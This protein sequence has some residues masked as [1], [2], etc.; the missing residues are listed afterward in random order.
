MEK[1][2]LQDP[3]PDIYE[4]T[5]RGLRDEILGDEWLM[6]YCLFM[7]GRDAIEKGDDAC[8]ELLDSCDCDLVEALKVDC[9]GNPKAIVKELLR[10]TEG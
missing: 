7:A 6:S 2:F 10:L 8:W 9:G 5:R 1:L 3:N 4:E